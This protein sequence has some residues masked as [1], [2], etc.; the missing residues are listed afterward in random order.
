MIITKSKPFWILKFFKKKKPIISFLNDFNSEKRLE[1]F[2]FKENNWKCFKEPTVENKD[3][4]CVSNQILLHCLKYHREFVFRSFFKRKKLPPFAFLKVW[5]KNNSFKWI[6]RSFKEK[7][8]RSCWYGWWW[9]SRVFLF[10]RVRLKLHLE[11]RLTSQF[12]RLVVDWKILE[13]QYSGL[14]SLI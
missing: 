13:N 1:N 10:Q 8:S 3:K 12:C 5:L 4:I 6:F 9:K 11:K 2:L 7:L 14:L